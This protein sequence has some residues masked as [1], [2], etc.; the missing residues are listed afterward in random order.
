VILDGRAGAW[1][2]ASTRQ[3]PS[4]ASLAVAD[5]EGDGD[6]E[7][8]TAHG[9]GYLHV[10]DHAGDPVWS[11]QPNAWQELR[12]LAVFDLEATATWR[13]S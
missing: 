5:L 9:G 13:S 2:S 4:V 11:R 10:F 3:R 7:I 12:S 8:V 1:I 6:L